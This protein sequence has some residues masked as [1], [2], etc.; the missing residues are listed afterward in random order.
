MES[1]KELRE[2]TAAASSDAGAGAQ[3]RM[4]K[5]QPLEYAGSGSPP[6]PRP[7]T[8]AIPAGTSLLACAW[9]VA[10]YVVSP[11]GGNWIKPGFR[12]EHA[13]ALFAIASL[14]PGIIGLWGAIHVWIAGCRDGWRWVALLSALM[15]WVA[16][17]S[18]LFV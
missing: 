10:A 7:I 5:P 9:L 13:A 3:K 18:F 16:F 4:S 14:V 8:A 1:R 12:G 15:Y 2:S 17:A 11:R 6:Q